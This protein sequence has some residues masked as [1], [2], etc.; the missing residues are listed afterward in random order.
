M[1]EKIKSESCYIFIF[2]DPLLTMIL[3]GA[4]GD[5]RVIWKSFW[6]KSP[7]SCF[8]IGAQR[9]MVSNGSLMDNYTKDSGRNFVPRC[10]AFQQTITLKMAAMNLLSRCSAFQLRII[11]AFMG[12]RLKNTMHF[13]KKFLAPIFSVIVN[14]K[15][16][17][18][19]LM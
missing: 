10:I 14:Y 8:S 13:G 4:K 15:S 16:S 2:K 1:R 19:F 9:I 5:F 7:L 18:Y 17:R 11:N 12:I 3:C 6:P